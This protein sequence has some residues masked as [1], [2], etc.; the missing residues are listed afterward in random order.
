[1]LVHMMDLKQL[2]NL[3]AICAT[4]SLTSAAERVGAS[5]Q[6]LS[7]SLTRLEIH[8]GGKLFDRQP[9]GMVLT[10]L[11]E[12]V[13]EHARDVVAGAKRLQSAASAEIGLESGKLTIGLSPIAAS[14]LLG[15]RVLEFALRHPN[16]RIDVEA[17]I[18]R[19]FIAALN[20]GEIDVALT[21]QSGG[22]QSGLLT[23]RIGNELWGVVGRTGHPAL[24]GAHDLTDL[25]GYSW[26]LGRN[27]EALNEK[28][29]A[30]FTAQNAK[31]PQAAM[32]TTSVLFAL[33]A[34]SH[35]DYL[36][37]LPQSLCAAMPSL[38]WRDMASEQWQSPV[39]L[40][41][42][43]QA[44]MS[45]QARALLDQLRQKVPAG[46]GASL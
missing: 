35:T 29:E 22:E 38:L 2:E 15:K 19:D 18:D 5:Q 13:V 3:L 20:R 42:R 25:D 11:G 36:S 21:S 39:Y 10:R 31:P 1:M 41:R 14:S 26:I 30:S 16:L 17:G 28:I 46:A 44:F 33:S 24:M 7:Q 40:M 9:R 8:L 45:F 32:M 12:T 37:I 34:L 23:E 4:G 27:T 43:K 6:A